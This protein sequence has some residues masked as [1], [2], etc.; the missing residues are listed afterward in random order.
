[1]GVFYDGQEYVK[2]YGVT[3]SAHPTPVDGDILFRIG[4]NSKTLTGTAAMVLVDLG[5]LN[6]DAPVSQYVPGFRAPNGAQGVTV[7]QVLN[8]SAGWLGYDYHDTGRGGD[9]LAKYTFDIRKLPQLFKAGTMFSYNNAALSVA[10]RVIERITKQSFEDAVQAL[11]LDP[12]GMA[13]THYFTDEIVGYNVAAGH[14][15]DK[16]AA[17]VVPE[18][19]TLPRRPIKRSPHSPRPTHGARPVAP[20]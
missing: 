15:V 20:R 14:V 13:D 17:V 3:N 8:H 12:I 5:Q 4:S 10:G 19:W 18:L 11:V 7:R 9:A 16:G 6:L 1:M 2:G